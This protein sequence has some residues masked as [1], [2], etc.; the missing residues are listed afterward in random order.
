MGE[1][2]THHPTN[3]RHVTDFRDRHA[4][5][6]GN[7]EHVTIDFAPRQVQFSYFNRDYC[8]L[9]SSARRVAIWM[10][11]KTLNSNI[12][13]TY[14]HHHYGKIYRQ[15]LSS[16]FSTNISCAILWRTKRTIIPYRHYVIVP[17]HH[18]ESFILRIRRDIFSNP[19]ICI[20]LSHREPSN[21]PC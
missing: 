4:K 11:S 15:S 6:N 7:L 9:L 14:H 3:E 1:G 16:S 20:I 19:F 18:S 8:T 17:I 2:R 13:I 12:I 5:F 10:T 21:A